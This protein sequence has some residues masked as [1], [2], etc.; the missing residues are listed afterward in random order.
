MSQTG[1][2]KAS[3]VNWQKKLLMQQLP[4]VF[5]FQHWFYIPATWFI[6]KFQ[7]YVHRAPSMKTRATL[8]TVRYQSKSVEKWMRGHKHGP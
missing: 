5:T 7:Y 4:Q 8:I 3:D 6:A 1:K 2:N